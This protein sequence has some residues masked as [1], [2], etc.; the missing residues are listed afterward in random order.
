MNHAEVSA[1][2]YEKLFCPPSSDRLQ[3]P[4]L[5]RGLGSY[6][7]GKLPRVLWAAS[8]G[9]KL[10]DTTD[11]LQ[12]HTAGGP[13]TPYQEVTLPLQAEDMGPSK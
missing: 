9:P 5:N 3:P 6:Y 1:V 13:Y 12:R 11:F 7:R 4:P 2:P 10:L 8:Y